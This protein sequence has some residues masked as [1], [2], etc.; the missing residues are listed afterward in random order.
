MFY[1]RLVKWM[2]SSRTRPTVSTHIPVSDP[3]RWLKVIVAD[4]AA[5]TRGVLWT[6]ALAIYPMN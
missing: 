3:A 2:L 5:L 6:W 1:P 4:A